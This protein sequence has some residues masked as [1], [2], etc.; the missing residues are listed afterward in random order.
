MMATAKARLPNFDF[1]KLATRDYQGPKCHYEALS[2][3]Q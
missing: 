3:I 2:L 1:T